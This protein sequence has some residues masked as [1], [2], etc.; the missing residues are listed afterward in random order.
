MYKICNFIAINITIN[1][2]GCRTDEPNL[3]FGVLRSVS[4]KYL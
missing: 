4:Q 3:D 1:D 2:A